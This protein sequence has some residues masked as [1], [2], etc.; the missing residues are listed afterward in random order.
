MGMKVYWQPSMDVMKA[1]A[2]A[3]GHRLAEFGPVE[4]KRFGLM[5][6][7]TKCLRCGAPFH[8]AKTG[9]GLISVPKDFE[10]CNQTSLRQPAA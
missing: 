7:R 4:G 10:P 9:E 2:G 3:A 1:R 5:V 6:R 8:L